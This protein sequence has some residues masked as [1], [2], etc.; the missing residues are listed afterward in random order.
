MPN[1]KRVPVPTL[2]R[3]STGVSLPVISENPVSY[4]TLLTAR[5]A[6]AL[7]LSLE[8]STAL[9]TYSCARRVI[10]TTL[11]ADHVLC[12]FELDKE[13]LLLLDPM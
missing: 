4:S 5:S 13:S 8:M 6:V 2:T 11:N 12:Y 9:S 10:A 3:N 1:F 7:I